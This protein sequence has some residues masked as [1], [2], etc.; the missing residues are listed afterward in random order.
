MDLVKQG[1]ILKENNTVLTIGR[2]MD[3]TKYNAKNITRNLLRRKAIINTIP[4]NNLFFE[5]SQEGKVLDLFLNLLRIKEKDINYKFI[6][7]IRRLYD[8]VQ[9]KIDMQKMQMYKQN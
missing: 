4:Y 7:E 1:E 8:T 2:Y 6:S 3:D 9:E 5:V